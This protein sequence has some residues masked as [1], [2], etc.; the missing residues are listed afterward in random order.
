MGQKPV[1]YV[2]LAVV[3]V[4]VSLSS[5]WADEPVEIMAGRVTL[6]FKDNVSESEKAA[7]VKNHDLVLL[8][9]STNTGIRLYQSK[10]DNVLPLVEKIKT[11]PIIEFAEANYVQK[12]RSVPNDPLYSNQWYL[13]HINMPAAWDNFT[14][15]S[16]IRVAVI[17]SG[18]SKYHSE[19]TPIL[20]SD[21]EWDYVASDSNANDEGN[22][23][24]GTCIAGLS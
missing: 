1:F 12:K 13:P 6:K 4:A 23:G 3:G 16:I 9:F 22:S 24:H 2:L 20:V 15:N 7:F 5:L 11:N 10:D 17:D 14:G 19:I 18:V 8:D 21:G